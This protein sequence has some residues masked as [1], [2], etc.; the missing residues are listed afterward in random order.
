MAGASFG[1]GAEPSPAVVEGLLGERADLWSDLIRR[2]EYLGGRGQWNWGGPKYGWE[3]K[4]KRGTKPFATLTPKP[5]GFVVLVILGRAEVAEVD[6][7]ALGE[8]M[9]VTFES[10]RQ[11]PDGRWLFHPVESTRDVE[12][13][14]ALLEL[15][16][17][18]TVRARLAGSRPVGS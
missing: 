16:L 5:G 18:P 9:R 7:T 2:L 13:A 17:P 1:R 11:F 10:A 12:D 15:K 3:L 4:F 14:A 6:P 8:G